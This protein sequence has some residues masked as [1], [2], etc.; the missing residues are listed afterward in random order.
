MQ[1]LFLGQNRAASFIARRGA[2]HDEGARGGTGWKA[3]DPTSTHGFESEGRVLTFRR[4]NRF[5]ERRLA[6]PLSLIWKTTI[7]QRRT[8][9]ANERRTVLQAT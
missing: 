5:F 7:L 2:K 8:Q 6:K 9:D 4:S 3:A 1:N